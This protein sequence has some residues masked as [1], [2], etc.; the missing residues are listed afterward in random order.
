MGRY[1]GSN[2]VSKVS[3]IN[4]KVSF[5]LIESGILDLDSEDF[6]DLALDGIPLNILIRLVQLVDEDESVKFFRQRNKLFT[7]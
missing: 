1:F 5:G 4:A 6:L 2:F 7:Q 3:L